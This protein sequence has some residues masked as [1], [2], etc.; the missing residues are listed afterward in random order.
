MR[1]YQHYCA[2]AKSLDVIG[3]RWSLLIVRE[4]LSGPKRYTDLLRDLPGIATDMLA[5]R[6]RGLERHGVVARETLPLPAATAVYRLTALGAGLAPTVT[7]LARWG[8]G[9][10]GDRTGE[11]FR[12]HWLALPLSAS[13]RPD[14]AAGTRLTIRFDTPDGTLHARIDD[15]ELRIPADPVELAD[16][17]VHAGADALAA[18]VREPGTAAAAVADGRIVL[19]GTP[20][21]LAEF[22][23]AFGFDRAA[24]G[25]N[26]G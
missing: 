1:P 19:T 24:T 26:D 3:E 15:G 17:V 11:A 20:Q 10:L 2:V 9:L 13:F 14:R 22:A 18:T 12:S 16:V 6:L 5:T 4:L 7:E 25:R 21:A 8:V 23:A